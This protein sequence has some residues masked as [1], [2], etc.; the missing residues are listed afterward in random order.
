MREMILM[1]EIK[2]R[3]DISDDDSANEHLQCGW[4]LI[5]VYTTP[6]GYD[7]THLIPV[8]SFG[9][10]HNNKPVEPEMKR[11]INRRLIE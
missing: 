4:K 3:K 11:M 9:W 10:L 8:Y 1:V 2:R 7:M 5:G 6:H